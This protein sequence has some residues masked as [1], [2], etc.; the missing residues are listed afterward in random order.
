MVIIMT[1]V[2][3]PH[4]K[5]QKTAEAFLEVNKKFPADRTLSKA[6]LNNAVS[7][8]KEGYKVVSAEEIKEGKL[9]PYLAQLNNTLLHIVNKIEGYKYKIELFSTLVEAMG[10]LGLKPPE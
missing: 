6:L 9:V 4:D 3:I 10:V 1:T 7:T 2:W 5:A 8:T